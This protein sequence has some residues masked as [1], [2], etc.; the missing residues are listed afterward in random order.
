MGLDDPTA[1]NGLEADD[2]GGDNPMA[3]A[4]GVFASICCMPRCSVVGV[5]APGARA[6]A[7]APGLSFAS[8]CC[9]IDENI[10][11]GRPARVFA[12]SSARAYVL[13]WIANLSQPIRLIAL[14]QRAY[15]GWWLH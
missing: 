7:D 11:P 6:Y 5:N 3:Q 4:H 15:H 8:G 10:P 13:P 1:D 2:S 9:A 14:A 12:F